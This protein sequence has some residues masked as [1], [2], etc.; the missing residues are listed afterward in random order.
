VRRAI[1]L[2][3]MVGLM[4]TLFAG[5][6]LAIVRVGDN[7]PNRLVGTA[8]NDTLR[9]LGGKDTLVGRGDSDRLF[10]GRGNDFIN[11]R[12]PRPEGDRVDCGRGFDRVVVDPSTEDIVTGNCERVRVGR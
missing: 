1:I 9:G 10:G 6:A 4:L 8:E 11:A 12:D 3:A 5:T 2:L 7:G